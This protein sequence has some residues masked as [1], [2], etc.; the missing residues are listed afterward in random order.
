KKKKYGHDLDQDDWDVFG[1]QGSQEK[2]DKEIE[3]IANKLLEEVSKSTLEKNIEQL[4]ADSCVIPFLKEYLKN[5]SLLD[6]SQHHESLY[7][8]LYSIL[9][10]MSQHLSLLNYFNDKCPSPSTSNVTLYDLLRHMHDIASAT[11]K[12]VHQI[13]DSSSPDT[14]LQTIVESIMSTFETVSNALHQFHPKQSFVLSFFNGRILT[15]KKKN[16]FFFCFPLLN[17][18]DTMMEVDEKNKGDEKQEEVPINLY[19]TTM[20]KYRFLAVDSEDKAFLETHHFASE[21]TEINKTFVSRL[22]LEYAELSK[23]LPIHA[24]SSIFIRIHESK[25]HFAKV[26]IIPCD[27]TPYGGGC[28]IFGY[29]FLFF[30]FSPPLQSKNEKTKQTNKK[31]ANRYIFSARLSSALSQCQFDDNW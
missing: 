31:W 2:K 12:L 14:A 24:D 1:W 3:L 27:G 22:R 26:L 17:T 6:I 8:T 9:K 21:P 29:L 28:F 20:K 7:F 18:L 11:S 23:S 30:I 15:C 10:K 19:E 13:P 5:D 25:M 16:F 4:F